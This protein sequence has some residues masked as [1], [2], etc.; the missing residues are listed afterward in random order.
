MTRSKGGTGWG[1]ELA[2]LF[3]RP[4]H[5]YDQDRKGWFSWED[6]TW[7]P[8]LPEIEKHTFAGTGT[9]NLTDDGKKALYR[10]LFENAISDPPD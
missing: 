1:V 6:N 7:V 5:V 2:R 4:V 3:N 9:R 10:D 8:Q